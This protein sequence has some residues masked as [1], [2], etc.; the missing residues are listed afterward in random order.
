MV[1]AFTVLEKPL[2]GHARINDQEH[3]GAPLFAGGAQLFGTAHGRMSPACAN[4]STGGAT[5]SPPP[6]ALHGLAHQLGDDRALVGISEG[7]V[8]RLF[9]LVRDAEIHRRYGLPQC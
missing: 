6:L 8:K 5:L 1:F 2:Q 7:G 3:S 4:P 9:H